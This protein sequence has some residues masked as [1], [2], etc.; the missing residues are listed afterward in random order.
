MKSFDVKDLRGPTAAITGERRPTN[1]TYIDESGG[2][3]SACMALLGEANPTNSTF[4]RRHRAGPDLRQPRA[5]RDWFSVAVVL[6]FFQTSSHSENPE[7]QS[8][9][10][11]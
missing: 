3:E 9:F 6:L 8:V 7:T 5:Q 11:K 4:E 10:T 1:S 2:S